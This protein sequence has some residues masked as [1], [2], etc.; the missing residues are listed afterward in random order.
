MYTP[1][2][3]QALADTVL[4]YQQGGFW[5]AEKIVAQTQAAAKLYPDSAV[6]QYYLGEALAGTY[7]HTV[8]HPAQDKV[9]MTAAYKKAVELGDDKTVAAAKERLSMYP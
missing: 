1:G 8:E 5:S 9:A 3:L 6:I 2:H 7:Y 4:A